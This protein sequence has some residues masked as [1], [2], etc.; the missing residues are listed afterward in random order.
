MKT[1]FLRWL[2]D[3]AVSAAD[4]AVGI[5]GTVDLDISGVLIP[6]TVLTGS[7]LPRLAMKWFRTRW[8]TSGRAR[9]VSF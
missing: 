8:R 3:A 2:F 7:H 5:G 4:P 9:P 6:F 1:D